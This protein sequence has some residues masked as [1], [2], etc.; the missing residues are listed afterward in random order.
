M[1]LSGIECPQMHWDGDNVKENW[2]RF[3]QH[4][5]LMFSGRLQSRREAKKYSYLLIWVGKKGRDI[6]N[7]WTDIT[8]DN[9]NNLQTYYDRF[10]AYVSLRANPVFAIFE[11]HGR[12]QGSSETAEQ[13][14]TD[15]RMLAQDCDF[16]DSDEM[17]RDGIV[18]GTNSPKVREKLISKGSALTLDK[19]VELARSFEAS[20]AQ[21]SALAGSNINNSE[22]SVHLVQKQHTGKGPQATQLSI[23]QPPRGTRLCGNCGRSHN[24][25]SNCPARGQTCLYCKKPH[26]FAEVCKSKAPQICAEST[27]SAAFE[28]IIF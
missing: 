27:L 15:L 4:V 9:K 7:T 24:S 11:F 3:K 19:A 12:V 25:L 1:A 28:S 10:E 2:R 13:F 17:I 23:S 6:Y 26:H 20:Q 21:L 16:K 22:E 8:A 14:I 5:E 18:F